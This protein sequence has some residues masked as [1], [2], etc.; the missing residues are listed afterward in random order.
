VH[1]R[2]SSQFGGEVSR[3]RADIVNEYRCA[4]HFVFSG[5]VIGLAMAAYFLGTLRSFN[6]GTGE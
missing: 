5:D 4:G 3:N 6:Q 2:H 1:G